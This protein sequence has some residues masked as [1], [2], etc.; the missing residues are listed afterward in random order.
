MFNIVKEK[1]NLELSE[2]IQRGCIALFGQKY[3]NLIVFEYND[4][5]RMIY[6]ADQR[7]LYPRFMVN[8]VDLRNIG[9]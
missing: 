9:S 6:S 3:K 4:L 8:K 2:E 1:L 5:Q 7:T